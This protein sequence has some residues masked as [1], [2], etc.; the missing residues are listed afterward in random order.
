MEPAAFG[1]AFEVR[2]REREAWA[3][4]PRLKLAHWG[5]PFP[6]PERSRLGIKEEFC[7]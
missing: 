3:L 1:D 4:L 6:V 5:L 2:V 7:L